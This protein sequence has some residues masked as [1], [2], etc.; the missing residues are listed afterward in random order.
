MHV[1]IPTGNPMAIV[2][3]AAEHAVQKI[4]ALDTGAV[5]PG[6]GNSTTPTKPYPNST[7]VEPVATSV[8]DATTAVPTPTGGSDAA[9]GTMSILPIGSPPVVP[10]GTATPPVEAAPVE[11][12]SAGEEPV[13][14]PPADDEPAETP[15]INDE[16]TDNPPVKDEPTPTTPTTPTPTPTPTKDSGSEKAPHYG[17]CGG[18][19]WE[20][21]TTCADDWRCTAM[22]DWYSQCVN[23]SGYG[24]Y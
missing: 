18:K 17:R 11:T 3:V 10:T 15:P 4:L 1:D 24:S 5:T 6:T 12:P 13:E 9:N 20:G 23:P 16:P 2:M 7:I 21:P 14:N 8:A 19:G 22:N